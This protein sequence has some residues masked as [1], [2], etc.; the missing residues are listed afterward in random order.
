MQWFSRL[1]PL[2]VRDTDD[3]LGL[4]LELRRERHEQALSTIREQLEQTEDDLRKHCDPP[5]H[6]RGT[7]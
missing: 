4:P 6:V 3:R 5:P 1:Y 7:P 2:T